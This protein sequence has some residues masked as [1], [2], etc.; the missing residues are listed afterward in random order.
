MSR[1]LIVGAGPIG[2]FLGCRLALEGHE[3]QILE[4]RDRIS[5]SARSIGIHP[6]ALEALDSV[7]VAEALIDCGV[8][9]RRAHVYDEMRYLGELDLG[10]CPPPYPFV[11][12]LPQGLTESLLEARLDHLAPGA[13]RRGEEVV[14]VDAREDSVEVRLEGGE[15]VA[16]DFLAGCDGHRSQVRR[17]VGS[18]LHGGR[19]E[20][21]YL[22]ADVEDPGEAG[23]EALF[24]LGR[25][26]VVESFPLPGSRRRWVA[27]LSEV[28]PRA[29]YE[30]L[31]SA[32][33]ERTGRL[34]P[35]TPGAR[36]SAF[37][38]RNLLATPLAGPRWALVGDAAHVVSP[39]GGQGMNLGLIGAAALLDAGFAA[40]WRPDH[41]ARRQGMRARR[42]ARRS[43]LNMNLGS[44]RFPP[45]VRRVALGTLLHPLVRGRAARFFTMR[46]L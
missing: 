45:L 44:E 37:T 6:P 31:R 13:I 39:I 36:A 41:Y 35:E 24:Y 17:G 40:A 20:D 12:S 19:R 25:T 22:M 34:L 46:G 10:P 43:L 15:I 8:A 2:L 28:P 7:G 11:L 5:P 1:V 4:M 42:A 29:E 9:I 32:V 21:H 26:G 14:A 18:R 33:A 30:R 27:R 23:S 3:V 16:G 38:A